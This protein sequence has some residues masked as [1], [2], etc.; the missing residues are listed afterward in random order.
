M[1]TSC[2]LASLR[3]WG[4]LQEDFRF[5]EVPLIGWE[6]EEGSRVKFVERVTAG[7]KVF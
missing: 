3:C 1:K 7:P 4:C 2:C 5:W 6:T